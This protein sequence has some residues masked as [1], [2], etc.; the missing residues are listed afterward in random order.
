M[1]KRQ[2]CA[3]RT[4]QKLLDTA[5]D[6]IIKGDFHSLNIEDITKACGCAKGSFYTYFK[7]KQQISCEVC[8]N[9]FDQIAQ[10]MKQMKDKTFLERLEHYFESFMIEVERYDINICREWIRNVID[11]NLS[12]EETDI[13]KWQFDIKML[14]D[15][16]KQAVKDKELKPDTP[17]ELIT[18]IIISELYGMMTCWCMS[19]GV[20]EPKDW[21]NKVFKAQIEPMLKPYLSGVVI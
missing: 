8:R 1:N 20:F 10:R 13:T 5:T 19:D 12:P 11:P 15:I 6:L 21:T 2:E 18:H 9:L 14:Q 17:V 7:N 4:R 3:L 16:L